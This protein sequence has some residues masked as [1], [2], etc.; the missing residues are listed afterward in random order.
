MWIEEQLQAMV[1]MEAPK[2]ALQ[3]VLALLV[4]EYSKIYLVF[5]FEFVELIC[6]L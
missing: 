6:I 5:S 3:M 4:P 2:I 1:W